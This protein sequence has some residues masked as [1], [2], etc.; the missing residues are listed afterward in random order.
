L[1]RE[2][3]I[4]AFVDIKHYGRQEKENQVEKKKSM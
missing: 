3:K 4:V 1:V 2:K